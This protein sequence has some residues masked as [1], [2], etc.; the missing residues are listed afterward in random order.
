MSIMSEVKWIKIATDIFDDEKILLIESLPESYAII[1][2]WFKLLCLAGK[3][4]NSGVFVM[5]SQIA[6]TDKMLS[7]IFRM[8][9]TIVKMSIDTFE[10][11]GMIKR[12]EGVITIPNWD[13]HQSL[14]AY[15]KK[16]ERDRR[17]Q[18]ERRAK[19]RGLIVQSSDE[20]SDSRQTVVNK[21]LPVAV[22]DKEEDIDKDINNI[23]APRGALSDPNEHFEK[24]WKMYPL[25]KG[26]GKVSA[27]QRKKL[28]KIS[29]EEMEQVI[30]RYCDYVEGVDYLHYQNG[31]TFFN[32][33]YVDYLEDSRKVSDEVGERE[34]AE[35]IDLWRDEA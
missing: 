8:K 27:T 5:N 32:S 1:T 9:E 14:D 26:K 35:A 17:Y 6:Y 21:S 22:S 2:V 28:L 11:F 23:C 20:S 16:K 10:Q 33:G 31:S 24:L 19:Q 30:K 4:N 34:E 29:E 25:K 12:V 3:Q 7:T 13:K 18:E 15:E